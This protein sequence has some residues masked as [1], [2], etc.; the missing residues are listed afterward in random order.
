MTEQTLQKET[1]AALPVWARIV[2]IIISFFILT[3]IFQFIGILIL[4]IP[5]TDREALENLSVNQLLVMQLLSFIGMAIVVYLFRVFI[6]K[7]SI[8]SL[9]FSIKNRG[10]DIIAGFVFAVTVIGGGSLILHLLGYIDLS[11]NQIN[12][13][14]LL[15]SFIL[16]IFVSLSEE[17]LGRGYILNNLL[18]SMNKYWAL[19]I[20]ALIFMLF[21]GMNFNLSPIAFLN[22]F[23]AGILLGA[24]YIYTK[25]LWFPISLHLFWNFFQGPILGYSVSGQKIDSLFLLETMGN[26]NISGGEFGFEG[27]IV[28]SVITVIAIL[29]VVSYYNKTTTNSTSE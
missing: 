12:T 11:Y 16:F 19:I 29:L 6:D 14:T 7:K 20:S 21:H 18:T 28:C 10:R 24:T 23:L 3:G 4:K 15:L 5:F 13:K 9:G 22:L 25:N 8:L 1:K 2:L 17:I 26:K 27:S